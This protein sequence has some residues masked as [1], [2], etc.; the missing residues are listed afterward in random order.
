MECFKTDS[1][2]P[3]PDINGDSY[4]ILLYI[5]SAGCTSCR[6]QLAKWRILIESADT[7]FSKKPEFILVFQ[8]KHDGGKEI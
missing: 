6:L 4:K 2:V 3:C 1:S 8:A 5:D 7:L